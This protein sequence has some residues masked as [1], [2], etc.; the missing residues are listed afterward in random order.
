MQFFFAM[1]QNNPLDKST[2]LDEVKKL[3]K[4]KKTKLENKEE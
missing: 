1:L 2:P 3:T 4:D